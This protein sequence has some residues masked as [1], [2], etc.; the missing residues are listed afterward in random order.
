MEYVSYIN[1]WDVFFLIHEFL[2]RFAWFS[3]VDFG[4]P[5]MYGRTHLPLRKVM[6]L[7]LPNLWV[8]PNGFS[9]PAQYKVYEK[10]VKIQNN[11]CLLHQNCRFKSKVADLSPTIHFR[12]VK[13][14][15][16]VPNICL[17]SRWCPIFKSIVA[18][19]WCILLPKKIGRSLAF[20]VDLNIG[21][22]GL[23]AWF[24]AKS[25]TRIKSVGSFAVLFCW[26]LQ[27]L[28]GGHFA[29]ARSLARASGAAHQSEQ[30]VQRTNF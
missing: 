6:G 10:M 14:R 5:Q 7:W 13:P 26:H 2:N 11:Q 25:T 8:T 16:M 24:G 28:G 17:E 1:R 15:Q 9:A 22:V 27:G 3:L 12:K 18:G 23:G 21:F 29:R 20:Q 19:F 4:G 30:G